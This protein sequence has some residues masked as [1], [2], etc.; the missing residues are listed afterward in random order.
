MAA[1]ET[2]LKSDGERMIPAYHK[3]NII[4]GEHLGRYFSILELIK[5]KTVLDIASGSGYGTQL[6]ARYANQVYGVD[7]SQDAIEY[8]KSRYGADNIQ[9]TVGDA[10]AIPLKDSSVDY[11]ISMETLEHIKDQSKFLDEIKRVMKQD[12]VLI[13]STPN[14]KVYPKGNHF[15]VKEHD[16]KSLSALL[17]K[18]FANVS[19]QYQV[20]SIAASVLSEKEVVS[21]NDTK[22]GWEFYKVYG[23]EPDESIYYLAVCS[24]AELPKIKSNTLLSQEYSHMEQQK[25]AEHIG[26]LNTEIQ[27][28]RK[29]LALELENNK[30]LHAELQ[31]IL[32][33]A[34]WKIVNRI[35]NLK[36]KPERRK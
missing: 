7:N 27:N 1:K 20:V 14:D 26:S 5:G 17:K 23:S 29:N 34:R 9:Y 10:T 12:G 35:A 13:L 8:S 30:R 2:G 21:D 19:I 24:D 11:V 4:Y 22:A 15:H 28:L 3:G 25:I 6:I 16:K 32:N 36:P 31:R 33:S 18:H